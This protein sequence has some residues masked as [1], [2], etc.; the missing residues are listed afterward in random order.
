MRVYR[1]GGG[2]GTAFEAG[3]Q[4]VLLLLP[5]ASSSSSLS[6]SP[7][8]SPL[9]LFPSLLVLGTE[10]ERERGAPSQMGP[11]DL[12]KAVLS[13]THTATRWPLLLTVRARVSRTRVPF[14]KGAAHERAPRG[15]RSAA[16][17]LLR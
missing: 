8:C 14:I 16:H 3:S 4:L 15:H 10:R 6:L 11:S 7:G 2:G 9:F 12:H 17:A 13:S 5:L 1:G